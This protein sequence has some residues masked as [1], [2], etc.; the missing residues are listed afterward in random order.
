MIAYGEQNVVPLADIIFY[1]GSET[2][3]T[4]HC[5]CSRAYVNDRELYRSDLKA[6]LSQAGDELQV[7]VEADD[8]D[9]L[10]ED[11]IGSEDDDEEE[12]VDEAE[13]DE[14]TMLMATMGL[15]VEFASSSQQ[16]NPGHV[17]A[18]QKNRRGTEH[19][20]TLTDYSDT[21]EEDSERGQQ[22]S[23]SNVAEPST[24]QTA[25]EESWLR[26]WQQQGESLLWQSWLEKHPEASSSTTHD[27]SETDW[28]E[29]CNQTYL[30]YWE[31]FHY[32]AAQG[33]TVD[34][35]YSTAAVSEDDQASREETEGIK[36]Q[37]DSAQT[38]GDEEQNAASVTH[39]ISS[40]S[41]TEYVDCAEDGQQCLA[42]DCSDEPCD[43]GNRKR[44]SSRR[45]CTDTAADNMQQSSA[46]LNNG[47]GQSVKSRSNDKD[48][49]DDDDEPPESRRA[50]VKRGHEL[51]AD[52]L[53]VQEAWDA[54]GLRRGSQPKFDSV[55]KLKPGQGPYRKHAVCKIN[56]HV[57][58]TDD[59]PQTT[60][61]NVSKTLQKVQNFLLQVQTDSSSGE[62]TSTSMP[63]VLNESCKRTDDVGPS[64]QN[65]EMDEAESENAS[66]LSRTCVENE[67]QQKKMQPELTP[68][69]EERQENG[70][71]PRG[72]LQP[73]D[74]PDFLLPDAPEDAQ[75]VANVQAL[76]KKKRKNRKRRKDV[77]MPPEIAAEPEL[78]KY[79]AQRYRLFSRFDEGIKLDHEGWFS[80]TPEKIAEHIALRVQDS[81]SAELII[82][83]FCG[84]GGNAIQFALTGKRVIAID[85]DPVRLALAQHNAEVYGVGDQ[86]EFLQGDFLQLAP[87]LRGDVVFLSPPWGGPEYLSADV[88]NIKTM[89][90]PDGFE[91]FRLSKMISDNI[92][93][94]LPRNAD[95]EQI[96]S[97][98]GPGGKVE[99][100]QN[101]LN[102]KLKTITA[103]FG[104][105]IKTKT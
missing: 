98:A 78:A 57:F 42:R 34:E 23:L 71:D 91:I 29:H 4:I 44:S 7:D 31:Q 75:G 33:W 15:P 87:G 30:Y 32:W 3:M 2:E 64:A 77:E 54:L 104:N 61:P 45:A 41:L 90:N 58:F 94:F 35:S 82:D 28:H 9:E 101:F 66:Q 38:K 80:V 86:I 39:L 26:Y 59:G 52:E 76:K 25:S 51:D 53:P 49:R 1:K 73:L 6:I 22:C 102:N 11:H 56:E 85:I 55:V 95:M 5:L 19:L 99:V 40:L 83:A 88:F 21:H 105:L 20:K 48:Q 14:E 67:G 46:Q 10:L 18:I 27:H 13:V 62:V 60:K 79:W 70:P 74:V 12:E 37:T 68:E 72:E 89:M 16:K 93:Y 92:V 47:S 100:E 65:T 69:A 96:A 103:Y 97:L 50:K 24:E 84:V 36:N 17:L 63:E 81:F 8:E 43:G